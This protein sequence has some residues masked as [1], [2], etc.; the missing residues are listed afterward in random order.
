[1][2]AAVVAMGEDVL[3]V[4]TGTGGDGVMGC[5]GDGCRNGCEAPGL[6]QILDMFP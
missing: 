2:A 5:C 6:S 1:M 3:V 4:F